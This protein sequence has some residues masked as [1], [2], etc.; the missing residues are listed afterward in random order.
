M[1]LPPGCTYFGSIR[2]RGSSGVVRFGPPTLP[3]PLPP[4]LLPPSFPP[5]FPPSLPP[6]LFPPSFPPRCD[7]LTWNVAV[8]RTPPLWATIC[9]VPCP[10]AVTSPL[11]LTVATE[12]SDDDQ[13]NEAS[14]TAT[15][16]ESTA[17]AVT[18]TVLPTSRLVLAG[19][20]FTPATTW[21]TSTPALSA[22]HNDPPQESAAV[23]NATPL[24]FETT[25]PSA[26]TDATDGLE[27]DQVIAA[28]GTGCPFASFATA[29]NWMVSPMALRVSASGETVICVATWLTRNS[30]VSA[31]PAAMATIRAVPFAS[32]VATP[33]AST[34]A[35]F[36]SNDV[37]ATVTPD[38]RLPGASDT[39]AVNADV[40][41]SATTRALSGFT[42][43]RAAPG[44][45]VVAVAL[46]TAVAE[47]PADAR[48]WFDPSLPSCQVTDARPSWSV[49]VFV[50][51]SEPPPWMTDHVTVAPATAL[52]YASTAWT[53]SGCSSFA[54]GEPLCASPETFVSVATGPGLPCAENGTGATPS[55]RAPA[56]FSPATSESV[57]SVFARPLASVF[58][59]AG[60]SLPL[61]FGGS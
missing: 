59:T 7:A 8:P 24:A 25:N 61:A 54:P 53:T 1:T 31:L 36:G 28:P 11:E 30:A 22:A 43:T 57:H 4:P 13:V 51:S 3:P 14:F 37:Q 15:P 55:T 33:D 45:D 19:V 41:P 23:S 47:L 17:A 34:F 56:R 44:E 52:P 42:V 27:L 26:F 46:N 6:S 38:M 39:V 40:A 35:T 48:T 10:T 29:V 20:T 2:T 58:V 5:L 18:W 60:S 32:A 21:R 12:G 49:S 50:R 16:F 9:T